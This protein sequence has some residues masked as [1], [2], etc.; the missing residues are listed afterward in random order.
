MNLLYVFNILEKNGKDVLFETEVQAGTYIR[1][2]IHDIGQKIG[3]GAHMAQ[4][5]RTKAGP[6]DESTAVNLQDLTDAFHFWKEDGEDE[7]LRKIIR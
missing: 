6:F 5:R 3:I 2:L 1:K 7:K 4:L